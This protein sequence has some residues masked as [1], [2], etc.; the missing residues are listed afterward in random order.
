MS[1]RLRHEPPFVR[2]TPEVPLRTRDARWRVGR[3]GAERLRKLTGSDD[4]FFEWPGRIAQIGAILR[5][6]S[7]SA[8]TLPGKIADTQ[9]A[10]GSMDEGGTSWGFR[11][12]DALLSR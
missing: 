4:P 9:D 3:W 5:S 2:C 10:P 6:E 1:P 11:R 7:G 12:F 8:F